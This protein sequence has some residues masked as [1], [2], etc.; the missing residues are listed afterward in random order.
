MQV[1]CRQVVAAD[2]VA[3]EGVV[4]QPVLDPVHSRGARRVSSGPER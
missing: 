3:L 1:V 2:V 4:V